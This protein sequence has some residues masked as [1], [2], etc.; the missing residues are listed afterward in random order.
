MRQ[1]RLYGNVAAVIHNGKDH[2]RS[3]NGVIEVPE[4]C[5]GQ[6]LAM[7]FTRTPPVPAIAA[8]DTLAKIDAPDVVALL[9]SDTE[10]AARADRYR[11][12]ARDNGFTDD[13]A[14]TA[15][16]EERLQYDDLIAAGKSPEEANEIVWP[17]PTLGAVLPLGDIAEATTAANVAADIAATEAKT[18]DRLATKESAAALTTPKPE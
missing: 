13:A 15:I 14:I 16:V 3:V 5:V 6:A 10:K 1:V 9:P 12:E 11:Q 7:G 18:D 2:F 8:V 4:M 17:S